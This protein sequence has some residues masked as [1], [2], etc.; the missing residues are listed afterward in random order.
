VA[1]AVHLPCGGGGYFHLGDRDIRN[2]L[3]TFLTDLKRV[4]GSL[5]MVLGLGPSGSEET[6]A[7]SA[8]RVFCARGVRIS[9]EL[10]VPEV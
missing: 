4:G 10:D 6:S 2:H 3:V 1:E 9:V 7:L 8:L 5:V